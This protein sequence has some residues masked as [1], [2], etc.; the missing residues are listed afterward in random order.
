MYVDLG[1]FLSISSSRCLM[2]CF[3]TLQVLAEAW[4]LLCSFLAPVWTLMPGSMATATRCASLNS[5]GLRG[6]LQPARYKRGWELDVLEAF[7]H[8]RLMPK[9]NVQSRAHCEARDRRVPGH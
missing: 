9:C 7:I 3:E 1:R 6:D 2:L 8:E 4:A 5:W